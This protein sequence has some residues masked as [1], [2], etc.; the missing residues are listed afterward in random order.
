MMNSMETE[1]LFYI[2]EHLFLKQFWT[3]T[4]PNTTNGNKGREWCER[5][6]ETRRE[7]KDAFSED[8]KQ[9]EIRRGRKLQKAKVAEGEAHTPDC[10]K[11]CK[12]LLLA[13]WR[14]Q[15]GVG[16]AGD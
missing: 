11:A 13:K 10:M 1:A 16:K 14:K 6:R 4:L 12:N 15:K 3:L 9:M 7:K 2:R 8:L 5:G